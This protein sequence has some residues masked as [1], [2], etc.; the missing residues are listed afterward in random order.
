MAD[1]SDEINK[2]VEEQTGFGNYVLKDLIA[3]MSVF[4]GMAVG[5][6]LGFAASK[7]KPVSNAVKRAGK[8]AAGRIKTK[9]IDINHIDPTNLEQVMELGTSQLKRDYKH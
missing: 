6:G 8:W 7:W 1:R 2:K 3:S 4:A 9:A 5:L